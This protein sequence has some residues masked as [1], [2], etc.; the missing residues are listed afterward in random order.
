MKNITKRIIAVILTVTLAVTIYPAIGSVRA[1]AAPADKV[2]K[3]EAAKAETKKDTKKAKDQNT[4]EAGDVKTV[5]NTTIA[6]NGTAVS[7]G[8]ETKAGFL[9][10]VA[11]TD[12]KTVEMC[13]RDSHIDDHIQ[14]CY[15]SAVAPAG[16]PEKSVRA[17]IPGSC[18]EYHDDYPH[19]IP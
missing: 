11:D 4:A 9:N 17:H 18:Q 14:T 12:A 3:T 15:P 19:G 2:E 7:A 6:G 1:E 16:S 8:G 13:I 10:V 5:G